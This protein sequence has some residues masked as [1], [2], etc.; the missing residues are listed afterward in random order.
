MYCQETSY[1]A[2][3]SSQ[4]TELTQGIDNT[5]WQYMSRSQLSSWFLDMYCHKV[6]SIP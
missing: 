5:L 2:D 6:L 1:S 3:T 4:L